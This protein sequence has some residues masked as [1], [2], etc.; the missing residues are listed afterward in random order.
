[1]LLRLCRDLDD[2][3]YGNI[4]YENIIITT[5]CKAKYEVVLAFDLVNCHRHHTTM[6]NFLSE[7]VISNCFPLKF[8][9]AHT[10]VHIE[11]RTTGEY[12][13]I[14][15]AVSILVDVAVF[16]RERGG[17]GQTTLSSSFFN[18]IFVLLWPSNLLERSVS[19]VN[20]KPRAHLSTV[21]H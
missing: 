17:R 8:F 15:S 9:C 12:F 21:M 7:L 19:C 3:F 10:H 5:V 16:L 1:M 6:E 20:R 11:I 2:I 14:Y 18:T 13:F 4:K